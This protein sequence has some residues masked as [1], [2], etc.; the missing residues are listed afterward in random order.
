M[1]WMKNESITLPLSADMETLNIEESYYF[2]DILWLKT[3]PDGHVR[4]GLTDFGQKMIGPIVLIR[5]RHEGKIL[6]QNEIFGRFHGSKIWF[7]PFNAPVS[8]KIIEVNKSV[9]EDPDIVNRDPYGE[10]WLIRVN[11]PNLEEQLKTL[12]HGQ[13]QVSDLIKKLA[14]ERKYKPAFFW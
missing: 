14:W 4:V 8:G 13:K 2:K 1:K 5:L 6:S 10:G 11:A 12:V 9:I 7:G 3:E